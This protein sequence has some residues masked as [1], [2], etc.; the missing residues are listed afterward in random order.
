MFACL[1]VAES[2]V[3]MLALLYSILEDGG[4]G[5]DGSRLEEYRVLVEESDGFGRTLKLVNEHEDMEVYDKVW[6]SVSSP[7]TV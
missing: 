4:R 5:G 1:P 2:L 7:S 3:V 6:R